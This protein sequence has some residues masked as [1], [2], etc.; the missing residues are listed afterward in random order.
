MLGKWGIEVDGAPRA[1]AGHKT[2]ALLAY[3]V[4]ATR[5]GRRDIAELLWPDADDP[6]AAERWALLQVRR[7][8]AGIATIE[9]EGGLLG[10]VSGPNTR[11]DVQAVLTGTVGSDEVEALTGGELLAGLFFD[12]AP[13][14]EHWLALERQRLRSAQR[15][16]FRHAALTIAP[17]APQRALAL[18]A[19]A[20]S[21][22]P[23]D[24]ALHEL[25]VDVHLLHD[26]PA[27]EA[28]ADATERLYR[29]ELGIG[30][31]ETVRRPLERPT[32]APANPLVNLGAA[33]HALLD[34]AS[35]RLAA[36]DYAGAV[37]SARRAARDAAASGDLAL[38]VRALTALAGALIH[39]VRGRD[40]EATG[41]LERALRLANS[42]AA[43]AEIELELGYVGFLEADYGAAE[44]TLRRSVELATSAG[45]RAIAGR[46]LTLIGACESDRGDLDAA[47]ATLADAL[48]LL[49]ATTDRWEGFA[50][51]ILARVYLLA[52]RAGEARA[53]AGQATELT[54]ER[55]WLSLAP[56]CMTCEGEA[57]LRLGEV[58][59]A[60]G[61]FSE[62]FALGCEIAD[63]CWEAL[64]LRGLA[65]VE[66]AAGQTEAAK[67]LLANAIG[68]C[69]RVSDVYR[70][71][72]ALV[73][74]DLVELEGGTDRVHVDRALGLARRG[75]MAALAERLRP[76]APP[77]A[78]RQ[79]LVQ[80]P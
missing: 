38:E 13:A 41:L 31:P 72:E 71:A 19:Q 59:A 61:L 35:A 70:W 10:V 27:A 16:A 73:L 32:R 22:D 55:G 14:F 17:S 36:G 25:A 67:T 48:G 79:T 52:G 37:D 76:F 64:S 15:D 9:A 4:L 2:W 74:T 40:H 47:A 3:L 51:S 30:L 50:L 8:L 5:T 20:V 6:L 53:S 44:A 28:Y 46:A 49:R 43:C 12:D 24:D 18:I 68:R 54:R 11:I 80:T 75:P 56:W 60:H 77:A 66:V 58:S 33:T 42:D 62:A 23:F 7:A 57:A 69:T 34:A 78:E 63:P 29:A 39:S 45:T 26:R 21:L 65:L 1:L